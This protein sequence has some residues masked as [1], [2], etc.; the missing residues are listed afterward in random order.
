MEIVLNGYPANRKKIAELL[1][2]KNGTEITVNVKTKT[3]IAK[4]MQLD[5][6]TIN[7]AINDLYLIGIIERIQRGKY[8]ISEE[9]TIKKDGK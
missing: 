3:A 9:Y 6:K 1:S 5:I 2:K 4:K 7:N 8:K